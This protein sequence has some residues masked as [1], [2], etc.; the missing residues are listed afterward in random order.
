[1]VSCECWEK[2]ARGFEFIEREITAPPTR[3]RREVK[4]SQG[5]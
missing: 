3:R 2:L 1:M 4:S 5:K